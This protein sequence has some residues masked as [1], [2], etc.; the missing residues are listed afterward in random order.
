MQLFITGSSFFAALLLFLTSCSSGP[1]VQEYDA[2][3]NPTEEIGKLASSLQQAGENQVN[4]LS[5]ENFKQAEAA[6][7]QA[8][9]DVEK[10]KAAKDVLHRVAEGNAY[11]DK[12]NQT[13]QVAHSSMEEVVV[14][15]RQAIAAGAPSFYTKEFNE[16]DEDLVS[17]TRDVEKNK[18]TSADKNRAELQRK[19]LAVE[20]LAIKNASL[21]PARNAVAI[22]IKEGAKNYAPRTLAIAEKSLKDA[23]AFITAN[24]H[25]T[26]NV[27]ERSNTAIASAN[28]VLKI[29]RNAKAGQKISS[30]DLA[31]KLEAEQNRVAAK[32][33]Q[34]EEKQGELNEVKGASR[35]L[36]AEKGRLESEQALDRVFEEA[37][38]QFDKNEAEVYKQG[39][40]LVIRLK[41]LEFPSAQAVLK[42][43][44]FP[45]L[46]K[47]QKVIKEF[48]ESSV[49]VEGHTD[50]LGGKAANEKLSAAR[51][52]AVKDYLVS[53]E[54]VDSAK[55]EAVGF[56]YQK[57]LATNKTSEGRAQNRR[58]DVRIQPTSA[59]M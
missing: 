51:A 16:V 52:E 10:Q 15:R 14:A 36:A 25:D 48:G 46:A 2:T 18:L 1:T 39:N 5:P 29:T 58:V 7:T 44:N 32:Q 20:L 3:A 13:A 56:G 47:V 38:A 26:A 54:A 27:K 22:A 37:R 9:R 11:L 33:V 53:S 40:T 49:V 55:I 45:L 35:D 59:N 31:L 30:E 34:L 41:G 4:V 8:K 12:A 42:G 21:G 28:H 17:V 19:Y 6:L 50:S 57:P 43:S 23:D 24:R